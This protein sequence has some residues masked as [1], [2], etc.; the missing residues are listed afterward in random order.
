[1]VAVPGDTA[2]TVP[3]LE[4]V[5]TA[6]F[7]VDHVNDFPATTAPASF[8]ATAASRT[9]SPGSSGEPKP[10]VIS[11]E[12]TAGD[13]TVIGAEPDT[14]SI[15]ARTIACPG[16]SAVTTPA[17]VIDA[18]PGLDADHATDLPA[19][20]DPPLSN[21]VALNVAVAPTK[22]EFVGEVTDTVATAGR[23]D[24]VDESE[25][26]QAAMMARLGQMT[27]RRSFIQRR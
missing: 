5:D 6:L 10:P 11:T 1:M 24:P 23:D 7:E 22:I 9:V 13:S 14:P 20:T 4:T 26:P 18:I 17:G 21:A 8:F 2:S 19:I 15:M 3:S 25:P 12:V 16:A 27:G